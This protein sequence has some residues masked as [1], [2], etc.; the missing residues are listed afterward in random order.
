[1]PLSRVRVAFDLLVLAFFAY[2]FYASL[3]F[4]SLAGYFPGTVAA[5]AMVLGVMNLIVDLVRMR[6][7]GTVVEQDEDSTATVRESDDPAERRRLTL[8]TVRVLAWVFGFVAI[9]WVVGMVVA[10]PVFLLAFFLLDER[11]SIRFAVIAAVVS[12]GALILATDVMGLRWPESLI[13]VL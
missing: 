4:R 12:T 13:S 9:I 1:M 11:T 10:V 5:L 2:I 3:D 8:R 6:R 7:T